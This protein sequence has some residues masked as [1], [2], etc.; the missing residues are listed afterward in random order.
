MSECD[1][2]LADRAYCRYHS[3]K[4]IPHSTTKPP[5]PPPTIAPSFLFDPPEPLVGDAVGP[6]M[7]DITVVG[8]IDTDPLESVVLKE[9]TNVVDKEVAEVGEDSVVFV[10]VVLLVSA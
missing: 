6:G 10:V 3:P 1:I 5:T 8:C 2:G 7:T 9:E 4:I